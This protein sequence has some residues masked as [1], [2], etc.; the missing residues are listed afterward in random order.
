[1]YRTSEKNEKVDKS[2]I[3]TRH[4]SIFAFFPFNESERLKYREQEFPNGIQLFFLE[5]CS[6]KI[7]QPCFGIELW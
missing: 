7:H 3:V 4:D 5:S 2:E 6:T 1:M